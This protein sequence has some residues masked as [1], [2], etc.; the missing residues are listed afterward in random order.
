MFRFYGKKKLFI[1]V[2]LLIGSIIAN[3]KRY[4][5]DAGRG[6]HH[7]QKYW[8]ELTVFEFVLLYVG[9]ALFCW[10]YYYCLL[11]FHWIK[12]RHRN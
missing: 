3:C 9:I 8:I 2:L 1:A 12:N 4:F 10:C 7:S 6:I 11:F 5:D